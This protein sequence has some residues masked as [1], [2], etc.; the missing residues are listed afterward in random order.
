MT[1]LDYF[2]SN[3]NLSFFELL[4]SF[5]VSEYGLRHLKQADLHPEVKWGHRLIAVIEFVP[6]LGQFAMFVEWIA[7]QILAAPDSSGN[8]PQNESL[9]QETPQKELLFQGTQA[10]CSGALD[11]AKVSNLVNFLNQHREN[12][13]TFNQNSITSSI[14][15]GTCTAMAFDFAESF[16][17]LR[18]THAMAGRHSDN[19]FL[20]CLR[21]LGQQFTKSSEE[22]RI[23]QAAFNTIEVRP[24]GAGLDIA[25]NKIQSLANLHNFKVDY[26]SDEIRVDRGDY[27]R[28]IKEEVSKLPNGL[29][30]LRSIKPFHNAREEEHGH[31][32]IYVKNQKEGFFYDPNKGV[33]YMK[34]VDPL[35]EL[36]GALTDAFRTF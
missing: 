25:K 9:F 12:G 16:F 4:Q 36:S 8:I 10:Q 14:E 21:N 27:D 26:S 23:R 2:I 7:F 33:K 24:N 31:S 20:N 6:V 18:N 11:P 28:V 17:K 13:I 5:V 22:M 30:L 1:V 3:Y 34:N 15:G 32:M 19:L 35:P 29:Y